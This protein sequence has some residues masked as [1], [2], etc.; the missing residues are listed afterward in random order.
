MGLKTLSTSNQ[1]SLAAFRSSCCEA[2]IYTVYV[3]IDHRYE[4]THIKCGVLKPAN[5]I[6]FTFKNLKKEKK[7]T[8][9]RPLMCD[10]D[11]LEVAC[12]PLEPQVRGFKPDRTRRIFSGRK[13]N[14]QH[15]FLRNGSKAVGPM[16]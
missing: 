7:N 13:K 12:W 16:S 2:D 1:A 8:F 3:S 4:H 9:T 14:F 15:A 10:F 11:V 5:R 6:W